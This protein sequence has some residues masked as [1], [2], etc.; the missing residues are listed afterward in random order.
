MDNAV[1]DE[2]VLVNFTPAEA[3]ALLDAAD[4]LQNQGMTPVTVDFD[5]YLCAV[6]RLVDAIR[7]ARVRES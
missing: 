3:Q 2:P 1:I 4:T 6:R 5:I 7:I